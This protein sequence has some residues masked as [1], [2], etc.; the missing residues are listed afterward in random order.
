MYHSILYKMPQVKARI[1]IWMIQLPATII[2]Y[3]IWGDARTKNVQTRKNADNMQTRSNT[4][5]HTRLHKI[6]RQMTFGIFF[7]QNQ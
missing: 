5:D 7:Q 1:T 3:R 2:N 6:W 4:E